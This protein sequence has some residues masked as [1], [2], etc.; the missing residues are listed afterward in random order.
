MQY[1]ENIL[2]FRRLSAGAIVG[3]KLTMAQHSCL[4]CPEQVYTKV[5][6]F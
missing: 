2:I 1:S 5:K 3:R 6:N 4:S